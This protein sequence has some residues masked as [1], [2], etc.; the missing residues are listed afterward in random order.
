VARLNSSLANDFAQFNKK[1]DDLFKGKYSPTQGAHMNE[2]QIKGN[3][4]QIKGQIK[5]KWGK[6][7]DDEVTQAEGKVDYLAGIVQERY[8]QTKDAAFKEVND[9]FESLKD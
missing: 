2:D 3:W 5:Q 6:L 4:K 9:Y 7:T 8:G 1:V